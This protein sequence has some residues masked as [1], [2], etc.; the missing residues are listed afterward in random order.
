[1]KREKSNKLFVFLTAFILI[2][3]STQII[4][5]QTQQEPVKFLKDFIA[6]TMEA[7]ESIFK[8]IFAVL[9]GVS[10]TNDFLFQKVLI[11][12][13]LFAVI[14]ISLSRT[15]IFEDRKS[16]I[17]IIAAIVSILSMRFVKEND[18]FLGVLLP[19]GALGGAIIIFLPILIYGIFVY[20]VVPGTFARRAAW[21]IY[22]VIFL[23]LWYNRSNSISE[24]ANRIYLIATILI[25]L[26]ALFDSTVKRFFGAAEQFRWQQRLDDRTIANLQAELEK[27]ADVNTPA[28]KRR[29]GF[30][31]RQ[32]GRMNAGGG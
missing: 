32:L 16:I 11:L 4:V 26:V 25:M 18:F 8:P 9:I 29:I 14:Y 2:I 3:L 27:I 12:F 24:L 20:K 17:F 19:Y 23:M 6:D 28:A 31:R 15:D 30:I 1:M 5:A 21:I 22:G 10:E 7:V 13:L